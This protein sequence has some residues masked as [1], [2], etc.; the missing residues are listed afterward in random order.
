MDTTIRKELLRRRV[1]N[2][3]RGLAGAAGLLGV[4]YLSLDNSNHYV[5]PVVIGAMVAI[6]IVRR[7]STSQMRCLKCGG[8]LGWIFEES[9]HN[10]VKFCP[11][12]GTDL[13]APMPYREAS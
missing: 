8:Y 4:A 9:H 13:D 11:R 10:R 1:P 12:C 7:A 6:T 2:F 3:P 5:L